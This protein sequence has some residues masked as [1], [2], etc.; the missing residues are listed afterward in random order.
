[1][2]MLMP[3]TQS[4]MIIKANL[5]EGDTPRNKET[6]ADEDGES[7]LNE[8]LMTPRPKWQRRR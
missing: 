5:S 6:T 7:E 3:Q 8:L 2:P 1:M 4:N